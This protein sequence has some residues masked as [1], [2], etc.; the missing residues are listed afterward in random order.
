[1][2]NDHVTT[3]MGKLP[4]SP[5]KVCGSDNH[6]DKECPDWEVYKAC[7]ASSKKSSYSTE[8]DIDE[9]DKM[10]QAAFS[11]L[12]SQRLATSQIDLEQVKSDFEAAVLLNEN[13][14]TSVEVVEN[15][16]K[17]GESYKATMEEV[18]DVDILQARKKPKSEKHLLYH[19]DEEKQQEKPI[20]TKH[21]T[22]SPENF[23]KSES[24]EHYPS[25]VN[26]DEIRSVPT[27]SQRNVFISE[28][29]SVA[30]FEMIQP[31]NLSVE[32][33]IAMPPPPKEVKPI[34]MSKKRFY[35][36]GESS[37]GVS[38]LSVKGRVGSQN[39][40]VTDLRL[41]SCADMTLISADYYDSLKSAPPVQ[42]GM[43]MRLWQLTDKDLTLKGFVRI[44]IFMTTDDG[45]TLELEAEAYVVPGMTV[46][47]LLGE[48]YQLTYEIAITRN[49]E[50]GPRVRFSKSEYE[51]PARHVERTKDFERL[52]Q[53]AYSV[54]RFIRSKLHRRNKNKRHRLKAKFGKEEKVVRAKED[55]KLRPHEC[56]PIQV[57]GHLGE[58][59]NWL[60]TKTLLSGTDD[61]YFAVP[62]TL[63]SA[64]NP[65]IP[66]TNPTNRPRYIRKGEVIGMLTD[67]ADYFDHIKTMEDWQN[68][69]KHADTLAAIIQI[70]MDADCKTH[71]KPIHTESESTKHT[72]SESTKR[73]SMEEGNVRELMEEE[74]YRP[75]TAEMLDLTEYP[76]SRMRE[77]ID[78]G[79]LPD[80]LKDKAWVMLER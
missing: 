72:E 17:T 54:G 12:L 25:D 9:G 8:K 74:S 73:E 37:V 31:N 24:Q 2:R 50:E 21:P 75:K 41:D 60:V 7:I 43:R 49:V 63:I 76:S 20:K 53:S 66:V 11:I 27:E 4:P 56:K 71:K 70:Q 65:W 29:R 64:A 55:Y 45:V 18:E 33:D 16:H 30:D 78:V 80:H 61:S 6:W 44:P 3:K 68:R 26:K 48:D 79:L 15:G 5:C 59:R 38:V 57:E 77:F 10:Y 67:P 46:P 35:P 62:N 36:T 51:I 23:A 34:R 47:I 40:D 28:Q 22:Q 42:Q 39:N 19:V 32:Q 58:D 1:M 14:T 69:S 52:R 13:H